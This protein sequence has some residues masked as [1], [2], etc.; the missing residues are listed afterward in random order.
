MPR[1][2]PRKCPFLLQPKCLKRRKSSASR[3][4]DIPG[5]LNIPTATVCHLA[6]RMFQLGFFRMSGT[7][8]NCENYSTV[9]ENW[10]IAAPEASSRHFARSEIKNLCSSK[11][12]KAK[13]FNILSC[14][15]CILFTQHHPSCSVFLT[16]QVW[17]SLATSS[18]NLIQRKA[19]LPEQI[20]AKTLTCWLRLIML[21]ELRSKSFQPT[22]CCYLMVPLQRIH[23]FFQMDFQQKCPKYRKVPQG[24][25]PALIN[26]AGSQGRFLPTSNGGLE[27]IKR[28]NS[29]NSNAVPFL[30]LAGK[31]QGFLFT[32]IG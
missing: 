30:F 27:R 23:S 28:L 13:H 7:C 15:S 24:L 26:W 17:P 11:W 10:R 20:I 18:L 3:A 6:A 19:Q 4:A 29:P 2:L 16:Q 32:E 25:D 14:W 9:S 1:F 12:Y 5:I 8:Q 22:T 31:H 21:T